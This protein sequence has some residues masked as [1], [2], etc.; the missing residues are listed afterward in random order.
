LI[1]AELLL[2]ELRKAGFGLVAGVPCSYLTPLIDAAIADPATRYIGATNEGDAVAMA[3]G[4]E[5]AGTHAVAMF[6]NSGLGNAV[7]PLTSLNAAFDV[8]I[9]VITTW[10]GEPDG[11]ADEPQHSMMGRITAPLLELMD[12]PWER[13]PTEANEV[14]LA[15]ERAHRHMQTTGRSYALIV[16]KGGVGGGPERKAHRSSPPE[17]GPVPEAWSGSERL[18]PDRV[19][20]IVQDCVG[21]DA[22]IVATTGFTGRALY[23]QEDVE[24]QLYM[25]GS[26]GC[27]SSL[28]L[29]LAAVSPTRRVVVLDGDGAALMRMG[30]L[31]TL[32]HERPR[33]LVHLLLDNGV[34]DSTGSQDTVSNTT[35]LAEVARACGYPK[36][37]RISSEASLRS[38]LADDSQQLRFVHVR[39]APRAD[40]SL[41]RPDLTAPELAARFRAWLAR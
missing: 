8:P 26:M 24:N 1:P 2:E 29:G 28:G 18:D 39:T 10:R 14:T 25:V 19:L 32:G 3:T 5:L 21:Q 7:N 33:N 13:L 4:A 6:Q 9:L 12:L 16:P 23:A 30:A 31:A 34:H 38:A 17:Q 36:V 35:D 27:A 22:A 37:V 40:R 20:R 15:L 41:P 11:P